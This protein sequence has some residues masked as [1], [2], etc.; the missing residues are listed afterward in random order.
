MLVKLFFSKFIS[1]MLIIILLSMSPYAFAVSAN[2]V[3][4]SGLVQI[5][6]VAGVLLSSRYVG[7]QKGWGW[8]GPKIKK[9]SSI[10]T[11]PEFDL[12][13]RNQSIKSNV[14]VESNKTSIKYVYNHHFNKSLSKTIGG[15]IEFRL[16]L[17]LQKQFFK[18]K[19][20]VLLPG[21]TGF[22]WEFRPGKIILVKFSPKIT[23]VHF[24]RGNKTRIRAMFFG[25]TLSQ[26]Q[27][28]MTMEVVFPKNSIIEE[29]QKQKQADT[30]TMWLSKPLN[31]IESFIDLSELNDK[32]AGK[33]GFVTVSGNRYVFT[34]GTPARFFGTNIQAN[35]LF[36]NNKLLIKKQA[37][38]IA[39]LGF[40]LVRL[41]HHD[42]VWVVPN[43]I[44]KGETT[45]DIND[46]ALDSYFW[47]VKCLR[48]EGIYI[49]MDLQVQRPWK[50]GD[51]IPGWKTDMERKAK[52]GMNVAKG[53][54]YLNER[55]QELT[56][57]FNKE[58]LTRVNPYTKLA[59]KDDPAVM[60]LL[61]T[62]ENDITH[63][64]GNSFLAN[65]NHPYHNKLFKKQVDKF[66]SKHGFSSHRVSETW[67]SGPS[68]Y[69]LN[70]LEARF[71]V[72]IIKD[73]RTIGVKI[74]IAT[75]NLWGSNNLYSLPALTTGNII[76][77][78]AYENVGAMNKNYLQK[79]PLY[80]PNFVHWLGQGQV[81]GKPYTVTEYNVTPKSDEI[82][83]FMPVI[84]VATMAAFQGWDAIM[85]Y[86]YSQDGLKGNSAS[87][88]DSYTHP[89]I[90]GVAP[91]M[92]MLYREGYVAQARK[93]VVLAPVNGDLFT[94]NISPKTSAAIRTTLE[95]HR[96]VVAMPKTKIL[97]WLTPSNIP[98]TAQVIHD[99]NKSLL[100]A[101]QHYIESDTGE[102]RR[103]W[104]TGIM[105][106]N[107]PKS[108]LAMGRIG[109][110]NIQLA[111]V[112]IKSKTPEAA[113]IFTSLDKKPIKNS[114]K[115]LLS[116]VAKVR[117]VK[118]KWKL[119]YISEP[120]N[121][122]LIL[123]SIYND[124]HLIPLRSDGLEGEPRPIINVTGGK[125]TF[126]LSKKDKTHW[127][128]IKRIAKQK[129]SNLNN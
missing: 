12:N 43:L 127:Y 90:M 58:L 79:N 57:K 66:S 115:I 18:A 100:P 68:K 106:V 65:K 14:R 62:N 67:K 30:N 92:A 84:S 21:N 24:E 85:L 95:Q 45:Q 53:F 105:T 27:Q 63:H 40:N 71:N 112:V 128:L 120:V 70:D 61:I 110:K 119:S 23:S 101:N 54:V 55:M 49:W 32:P 93:T 96:M 28:H 19:E 77:V 29:P 72:D 109:E 104:E 11:P 41:H 75:T 107:T 16:N 123:S 46:N 80:Q 113:I 37:K 48:D 121:A 99:L 117:K 78:H 22:S 20:P 33:H 89:A 51:E 56:K 94:K 88:W 42:S 83:A 76:D 17:K 13:F 3:K 4:K 10:N 34:D 97:P 6:G 60:S 74:P 15:G 124:L 111:D 9:I 86:G 47:W 125:Y 118:V 73:L 91:A 129:N 126:S 59:L 8:D 52:K 103:N 108:Q 50:K 69:F 1:L 98:K 116:T 44:R 26:G 7:W 114:E 36:V 31:P 122:S 25:G 81:L 38:R 82:G 87:P 5:S 39:K 64:F 35:S 102:I 2:F